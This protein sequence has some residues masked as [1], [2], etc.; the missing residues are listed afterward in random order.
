MLQKHDKAIAVIFFSLTILF[1]VLAITNEAFFTWIFHR[2][3]NSLSWYIR[4]FFLVPFCFFA[5]RR[6]W[7]G[8]AITVFCL[9]TSMFWFNQ[10]EIVNEQVLEF[11]AFEKEWLMKDWNI[12]KSLLAATIPLSYTVLGIAFWQRSLVMGLVV[13]VLMAAGKVSWSIYNAGNA[14]KSVIVPAIVG[15]VLCVILI[16][17]GYTRM[18]RK[19]TK[20]R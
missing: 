18:E 11:L 3:Q 8:I 14:G 17:W 5:Y 15:L 4:P 12:E 10:P 6:S 1:I 2:H 16:L 9:F 19:N 7:A 20:S 13:I